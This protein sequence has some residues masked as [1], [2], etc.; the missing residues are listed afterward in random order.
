MKKILITF[1]MTIS[2]SIFAQDFEPR[3]WRLGL[4]IEAHDMSDSVMWEGK[5]TSAKVENPVGVLRFEYDLSIRKHLNTPRI[6]MYVEHRSSMYKSNDGTG[7]NA[8]GII[9]FTN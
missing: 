2:F 3:K 7:Y 1:L 9:F 8:L 6:S 4:G 5:N